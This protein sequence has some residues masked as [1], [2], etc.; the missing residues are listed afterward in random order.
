MIVLQLNMKL[1][2]VRINIRNI[3]IMGVVVR[4]VLLYIKRFIDCFYAFIFWDNFVN[5]I[6]V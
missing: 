3:V 4:V 6:Y 5:G 1:L 2:N